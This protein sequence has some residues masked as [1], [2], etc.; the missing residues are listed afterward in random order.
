MTLCR[1]LA[2]AAG[3]SGGGGVGAAPSAATVPEVSTGVGLTG[4]LRPQET[5]AIDAATSATVPAIRRARNRQ[6]GTRRGSVMRRRTYHE[7]AP[8]GEG[9]AGP[10]AT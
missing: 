2:L 1:G 8:T 9:V 7:R 4:S 3:S 5:A 6:G 10:D